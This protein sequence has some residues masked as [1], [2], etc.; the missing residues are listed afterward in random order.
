MI[1]GYECSS[2]CVRWSI[3]LHLFLL[4]NPSLKSEGHTASLKTN[5]ALLRRA[6]INLSVDHDRTRLGSCLRPN[7]YSQDTDS[8]ANFASSG[9][10]S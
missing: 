10:T 1:D 2:I 8:F 4:V 3:M 9:L 5:T 6:D 7:L